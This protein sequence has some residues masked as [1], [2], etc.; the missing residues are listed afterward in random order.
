MLNRSGYDTEKIQIKNQ[1]N[2]MSNLA[3]LSDLASEAREEGYQPISVAAKSVEE[4][5]S[6]VYTQVVEVAHP[7]TELREIH[8]G[9]RRDTVQHYPALVT[10]IV[11]KGSIFK[12]RQLN[13]FA[14]NASATVAVLYGHK[15]RWSEDNT[16]FVKMVDGVDPVTG[17]EHGG[18][19]AYDMDEEIELLVMRVMW[20][21]NRNSPGFARGKEIQINLIPAQGVPRK[22]IRS[23]EEK[24]A[25]KVPDWNAISGI[26]RDIESPIVAAGVGLEK[27]KDGKFIFTEDNL[28]DPM[29]KFIA[30]I[31]T[32]KVRE[33]EGGSAQSIKDSLRAAGAGKDPLKND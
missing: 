9:D 24:R 14:E 16:E 1:E 7:F 11:Y 30:L 15:A 12:S 29:V 10:K 26:Q 23:T 28:R 2:I 4:I 25:T 17:D 27:D 5:R 32:A 22:T 6:E 20:D 21:L 8:A 3:L 33:D 18:E 31:R 19:Y 13:S